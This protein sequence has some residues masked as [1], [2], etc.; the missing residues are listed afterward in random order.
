MPTMVEFGGLDGNSG[1]VDVDVDVS[2]IDANDE[3]AKKDSETD[4]QADKDTV[5]SDD[6]TTMQLRISQ[7]EN[8]IGDV[9]EVGSGDE[10][11]LDEDENMKACQV[12]KRQIRQGVRV[13]K[14]LKC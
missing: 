11:N 5:E 2:R 14:P 9:V 6:R 1:S 7:R 3:A 4:E 13:E 8:F 12:C 10:V